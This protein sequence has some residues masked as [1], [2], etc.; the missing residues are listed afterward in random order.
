M[1][2]EENK[3]TIKRISSFPVITP[4][5]AGIDVGDTIMAVAIPING[6]EVELREYGCFTSDLHAM[7]QRFKEFGVTT[8]AMES[9]GVYWVQPFL[10]LQDYDIEVCLVNSRHTKNVTGRKKDISDAEW[11]QQLHSCGLL[12]PSF[13]P[14]EETRGLRDLMRNRKNL[15]ETRTSYL[16]R[17]QKSLEQMNIKVHTVISD[18]D[19]KT[20]LRIIEAIISGERNARKLANLADNRIK[21]TKEELIKSLEGYWKKEQLFILKQCYSLYSTHQEMIEECEKEIEKKLL[22]NICKKKEE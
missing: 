3:N 13:Q 15:V 14:E 16:N 18:I 20:G 17:M 22:E 6:K 21:A 10:L 7:A 1:S 12:K 8:V 9:T 2:R 4:T 19:G 5:A 11:I